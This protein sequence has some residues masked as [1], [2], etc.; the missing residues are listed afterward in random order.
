[1]KNLIRYLRCEVTGIRGPARGRGHRY[2]EVLRNKI[3]LHASRRRTRGE[4][5][6]AISPDF[7][8]P[9][10]RGWVVCAM[11]GSQCDS[12]QLADSCMAVFTLSGLLKKHMEQVQGSTY[13]L[14][15]SE[16]LWVEKGQDSVWHR[17]ESDTP[18]PV[19][20]TR[21]EGVLPVHGQCVHS[22]PWTGSPNQGDPAQALG[23]SPRVFP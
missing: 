20:D 11:G 12:I 13:S 10:G 2:P 4:S 16:S 5:L 6:A 19:R 17:E 23:V 3:V 8:L 22:A 14:L 7:G 1:M 18:P 21:A 9:G 15:V